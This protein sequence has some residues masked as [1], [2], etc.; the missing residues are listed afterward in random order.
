[1]LLDFSIFVA[2][3]TQ[4]RRNLLVCNE[5]EVNLPTQSNS[6][7]PFL[8]HFRPVGQPSSEEQECFTSSGHSNAAW[9]TGHLP[10]RGDRVN[11]A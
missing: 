4:E 7:H 11:A 5:L 6:S 1:M 3:V 9:K 2:E 10:G 8:Q